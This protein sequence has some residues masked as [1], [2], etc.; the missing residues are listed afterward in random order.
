MF[1]S[2]R[3][4][5]LE[6]NHFFLQGAHLSR[7][8]VFKASARSYLT[9]ESYR[10]PARASRVSWAIHFHPPRDGPHARRAI[11]SFR[12]KRFFFAFALPFRLPFAANTQF[13]SA[14][15]AFSSP[16]PLKSPQTQP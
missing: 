11:F 14:K 15:N 9:I 12:K 4:C 6:E 3:K 2:N 13:R 5:Q 1:Q 16:M 7:R 8:K 10:S